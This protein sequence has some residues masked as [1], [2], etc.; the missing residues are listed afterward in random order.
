MKL[1]FSKRATSIIV[2]GAVL[3]CDVAYVIASDNSTALINTPISITGPDGVC[4]KVTN[5]SA[6][7]KS[8]YIPTQTTAE[9]QSFVAHPPAG[10]TV[11]ACGCS[12]PLA[13]WT[14]ESKCSETQTSSIT[15]GNG[16]PTEAM[17]STC[18]NYCNINNAQ[19]CTIRTVAGY[20]GS[21]SYC[22]VSSGFVVPRTTDHAYAQ[23]C[24]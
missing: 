18:T 14:S 12:A 10:V 4:K 8:E 11:V 24:R 13:S 7:G 5:N 21:T 16:F 15:L 20:V 3:L 23:V 22:D 1:K 2:I 9:W 6:T 19:C 17:A